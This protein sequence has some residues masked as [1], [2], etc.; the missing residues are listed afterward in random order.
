MLLRTVRSFVLA[1][2]FA[3]S[4]LFSACV[5]DTPTAGQQGAVNGPCYPNQT[6]DPGLVCLSGK[7]FFPT[8]GGNGLDAGDSGSS[9]DSGSGSDGSSEGGDAM[10]GPQC[11]SKAQPSPNTVA[12]AASNCDV[13]MGFVCCAG[14]ETCVAQSCGGVMAVAQL[15]C[16]DRA[17]CTGNLVCCLSAAMFQPLCPITVYPNGSKSSCMSTCGMGGDVQLCA[18]NSECPPNQVCLEMQLKGEANI[19]RGVCY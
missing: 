7:C 12:C 17:D 9:S 13:T 14:P 8:D 5:G 10:M 15:A 19:T 2:L 11:F 4:L 1:S 18:V 6:C 16:D 3:G